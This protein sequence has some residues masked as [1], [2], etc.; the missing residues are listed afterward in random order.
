MCKFRGRCYALTF[1]TGCG[2]GLLIGLMIMK[3]TQTKLQVPN[4]NPSTQEEE[5]TAPAGPMYEEVQL[6]EL[7]G[8]KF[9]SQNVA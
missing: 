9:F 7:A 8:E 6:R 1:I 5:K 4:I 2:L 3:S